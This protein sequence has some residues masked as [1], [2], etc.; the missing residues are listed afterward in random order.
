MSETNIDINQSNSY[1]QD[2]EKPEYFYKFR[3]L[4]NLRYFLDIIL[5]NRLLASTFQNLNDPMEGIYKSDKSLRGV[6]TDNILKEKGNYRICSLTDNYSNPLMWSFYAEEGRG[7]CI[8]LKVKEGI[9]PVKVSYDSCVEASAFGDVKGILQHKLRQWEFEN[10]WRVLT[11]EQ[12]VPIETCA[13]YLC[14]R[15]EKDESK[16]YLDLFRHLNIPEVGVVS[17]QN[18]GTYELTTKK[19]K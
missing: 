8:K 19:T 13:I 6:V 14:S 15:M 3:S 7:C 16:F 10:E 1:N 18:D 9:E 17:P 2:N 12:Y 5:N 11:N 4:S